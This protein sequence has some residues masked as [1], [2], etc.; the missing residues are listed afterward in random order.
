MDFFHEYGGDPLK[1]SLFELVAQEQLRDLLQPALKY[2]LSVFAQR[3]PRYLLRIVNRH[4]EFYALIMLYVERHY[5]RK[6]NASFSEN[7]YGLKRRRKPLI[8]TERARAAV[9]GLPVEEK[10]R[11]REVWRSLVVLVGLPYLRAKAQDYY[12]DLGGGS[13][14]LDD[15][16][17][18]VQAL[19]EESFRGR[20]RRLYKRTYPWINL[21]F[22]G[23]LMAYNVAYAFE[24]TPFYR[25]WLSWIG[26][27]VRR[28]GIEDLR[29]AAAM[30]DKV[31]SREKSRG[32]MSVL[33]RLLLT[34]PR[35]LLDSLKLLLP[36][37]IFFIKFLEWWYSPSSPARVLST[38]PLGPAIPPP[39]LLP[40][41]PKGIP[42]DP[43]K[44]GHCPLCQSMISNATVL[45]SGYVFCY[46]CA[47]SHVEK[48][49]TCPVTLLPVH[50]WDL[51]K[52][53]V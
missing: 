50:T 1:P 49:G 2:V 25:P 19:T 12:E 8:E 53:L 39:R 48:H 10:L 13:D 14:L 40:P 26:V 29:A 3:H 34:S 28:L 42:V 33:R 23:W 22:E 51:R 4:E 41:H 17:R 44:F 9:G 45:P 43:T 38:S 6:Y 20:L 27:D 36:T 31:K 32:L 11:H 16:A 5:L 15:G 47:F 7:F 52:V 21:T 46:R 35:F 18:Q 24:R 30:G 37:A